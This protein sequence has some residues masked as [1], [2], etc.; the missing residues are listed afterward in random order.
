MPL[1]LLE[2]PG[3]D[4]RHLDAGRLVR[5]Q[6]GDLLS[7]AP[8]VRDQVDRELALR[9]ADAAHTREGEKP[10]GEPPLE[11][12]QID[13]LG[14]GWHRALLGI[15]HTTIATPSEVS[16]GSRWLATVCD[17]EPA[18]SKAVGRLV[19]MSTI[20]EP[21]SPASEK[22]RPAPTMMTWSVNISTPISYCTLRS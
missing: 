9:D 12:R 16:T 13:R 11:P 5:D 6:A 19:F 22:L 7:D 3:Y 10:R 8:P 17:P 14:L 4:E 18:N 2:A 20:R 15:L 1:L 21:E